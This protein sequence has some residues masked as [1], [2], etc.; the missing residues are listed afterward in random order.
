MN[1]SNRDFAF[2]LKNQL[3]QGYEPKRVGDW[4]HRMYMLYCGKIDSELEEL[5]VDLF[6]L[7][8]GPEF[9]IPESQLRQLIETLLASDEK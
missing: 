4:A 5:M 7:E 8:E 2:D 9:E 6:V 3:D 1:Y